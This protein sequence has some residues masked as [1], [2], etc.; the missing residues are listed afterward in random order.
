[1]HI[2]YFEPPRSSV[3]STRQVPLTPSYKYTKE[4]SGLWRAGPQIR[5]RARA[6]PSCHYL[7]LPPANPVRNLALTLGRCEMKA[8]EAITVIIALRDKYSNPLGIL[9]HTLNKLDLNHI[10]I[11]AKQKDLG[12]EHTPSDSVSLAISASPSNP[13]GSHRGPVSDRGSSREQEVGLGSLW[14]LAQ[15]SQLGFT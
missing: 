6:E 15:R 14:Y 9:R 7:E 4:M 3:H 10:I 12:W 5:G 11:R 2:I 1:M 8:L 13:Q